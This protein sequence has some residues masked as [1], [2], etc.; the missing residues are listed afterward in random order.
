MEKII[1]TI[2]LVLYLISSLAI[3]AILF[4][5]SHF[6]FSNNIHSI[7][8]VV[9]TI[10]NLPVGLGIFLYS[11]SYMRAFK[12]NLF[13]LYPSYFGFRIPI[14]L[15]MIWYGIFIM[16]GCLHLIVF[17]ILILL[18]ILNDFSIPK[19]L[20]LRSLLDSILL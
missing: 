7:L 6:D 5:Y 8:Y 20:E 14:P 19:P 9:F 12:P 11:Y 3:F 16:L 4:V 2:P 18:F 10:F 1:K 13:R 15:D 17:A